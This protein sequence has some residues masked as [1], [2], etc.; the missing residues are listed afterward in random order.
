MQSND[1]S[2]TS[3][4][5]TSGSLVS[6]ASRCSSTYASVNFK[7]PPRNIIIT[8][9]SINDQ[10]LAKQKRKQQ[11][12][13]NEREQK[14]LDLEVILSGFPVKPVVKTVVEKLLSINKVTLDIVK[15][16]HQFETKVKSFDP[17]EKEH[18]EETF[19]YII[20]VFKEKSTISKLRKVIRWSQLSDDYQ[21][22]DENPLISCN[23]RLSKFNLSV[24]KQLERLQRKRIIEAFTFKDVFHCY[25]Q[26]PNSEWKE[27]SVIDDIN[28]LIDLLKY[29]EKI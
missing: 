9:D 1:A 19:F 21:L 4:S 12:T 26:T 24:K 8:K 6:R 22:P 10:K 29:V 11:I 13:E 16:Y 14:R 15:T 5:S 18:I 7:K 20:I 2:S 27:V 28:H 3:G 17:I 23:N 25:Q